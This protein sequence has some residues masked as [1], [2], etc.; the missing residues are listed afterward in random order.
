M[1]QWFIFIERKDGR[2]SVKI[3]LMNIRATRH[4]GRD[5]KDLSYTPTPIPPMRTTGVLKKKYLRPF[6]YGRH[7]IYFKVI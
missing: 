4:S 3:S 6:K 1:G 2:T 7:R 5:W